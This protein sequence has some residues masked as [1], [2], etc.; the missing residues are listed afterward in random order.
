MKREIY[1]ILS[2]SAET[3]K[4]DK[5][6]HLKILAYKKLKKIKILSF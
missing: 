4:N 3:P 2:Q 1:K 6:I 5:K